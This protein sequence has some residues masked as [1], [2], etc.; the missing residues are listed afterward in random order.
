LG[1]S[2]RWASKSFQN[3][4]LSLFVTIHRP[5][6]FVRESR[7]FVATILLKSRASGRLPEQLRLFS[8]ITGNDR[9]TSN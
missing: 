1:S 9:T 6:A 4:I 5:D 2:I 7:I 3:F 8:V